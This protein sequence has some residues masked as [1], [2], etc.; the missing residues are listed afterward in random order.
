VTGLHEYPIQVLFIGTGRR[1]FKHPLVGTQESAVQ[2]L[3]SLQLEELSVFMH[4]N[5]GE[6]E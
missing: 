2:T 1:V 4:L 3:L 6:S 5:E